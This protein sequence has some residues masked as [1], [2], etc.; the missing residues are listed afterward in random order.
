MLNYRICI[1]EPSDFEYSLKSLYTE[2]LPRRIIEVLYLAS[3][4]SLR[5]HQVTLANHRAV[6]QT[7]HGIVFQALSELNWETHDFDIILSVDDLSPAQALRESDSKTPLI[8]WSQQLSGHLS[9]LPL[10]QQARQHYWDAYVFET[11]DLSQQYLQHYQLQPSHTHYRWPTMIR[12][13]RNRIHNIE[14]LS[15]VRSPQLTLA[16]TASPSQGLAELLQAFALLKQGFSEL[17]L[18]VLLPPG[19]DPEQKTEAI[20]QEVLEQARQSDGVTVFEPCPWPDYVNRLLK[21][22]LVCNPRTATNPGG[23]QII[24]ALAAGCLVVAEKHPSLQNFT[25]KYLHSVDSEPAEDYLER[26]T[27][28]IADLLAIFVNQPEKMSSHSLRQIAYLNTTFTWDLRVW[29]WESLMFQLLNHP[30]YQREQSI[31]P[32]FSQET[33]DVT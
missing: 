19:Y 29:E 3:A 31:Q 23:S 32:P 26:Y 25:E 16:F 20:A 6:S 18:W 9:M 33:Q 10:K 2:A 28:K 27:Q 14:D 15:K 8:L 5:P 4:L 24:D 30:L 1:I 11:M 13:L 21:A 22:H 17:A 12:T 7:E